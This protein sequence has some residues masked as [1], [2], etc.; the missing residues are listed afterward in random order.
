[1][2]H[3][4]KMFGAHA[5]EEG[6]GIG[7]RP[8]HHPNHHLDIPKGNEPLADAVLVREDPFDAGKLW[9]A[10]EQPRPHRRHGRRPRVP[11]SPLACGPHG[12][13]EEEHAPNA[14]GGHA[15]HL[16]VPA[17]ERTENQTRTAWGRH[18]CHT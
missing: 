16:V 18:A 17:A 9:E 12:E 3:V 8:N 7:P 10:L 1:M 4:W 6:D 13:A 5:I 15:V 2:A 14:A 11:P